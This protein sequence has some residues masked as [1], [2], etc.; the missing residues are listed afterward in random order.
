MSDYYVVGVYEDFRLD[1]FPTHAAPI[2]VERGPAGY[3]R[4]RYRIETPYR[5]RLLAPVG[6]F[7]R[8]PAELFPVMTYRLC[9]PRRF[10]ETCQVVA[11]SEDEILVERSRVVMLCKILIAA[12][13]RMRGREF[14]SRVCTTMWNALR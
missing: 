7:R 6:E 1:V 3:R 2:V 8:S 9:A 10:S 5:I 14:F 4:W 11:L 13:T 12:A